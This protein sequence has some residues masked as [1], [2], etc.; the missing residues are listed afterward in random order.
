[1]VENKFLGVPEVSDVRTTAEVAPSPKSSG[2]ADEAKEFNG[3]T[4]AAVPPSGSSSL[5]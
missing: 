2:S 3:G 4:T 5:S 1:M